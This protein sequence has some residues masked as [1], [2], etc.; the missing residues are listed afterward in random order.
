MKII[1]YFNS[2]FEA[3][4][5]R[6]MLENEGIKA[7]V[8]NDNMPYSMPGTQSPDFTKPCLAVADENAQ[9]AMR[10]IEERDAAEQ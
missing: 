9:R 1:R 5:V 10:L 7:M 2:A 8:L 3:E 4:V 6:G